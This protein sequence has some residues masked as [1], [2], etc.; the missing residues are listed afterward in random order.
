MS[1]TVAVICLT[2]AATAITFKLEL[3]QKLAHLT[4]NKFY[5]IFLVIIFD[6]EDCSSLTARQ[7]SYNGLAVKGQNTKRPN[8]RYDTYDIGFFY[9]SGKHDIDVNLS[10]IF[11]EN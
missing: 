9:F 5:L 1:L 10:E 7:V 11:D 2:T 8:N 4:R 6:L 3:P